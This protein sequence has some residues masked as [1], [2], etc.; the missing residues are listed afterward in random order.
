MVGVH[1]ADKVAFIHLLGEL[2]LVPETRQESNETQDN[3][4]SHSDDGWQN[5]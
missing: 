2:L 3:I 4:V 1:G 5:N